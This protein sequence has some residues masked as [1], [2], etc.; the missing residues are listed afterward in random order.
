MNRCHHFGKFSCILNGMLNATYELLAW[1]EVLACCVCYVMVKNRFVFYIQLRLIVIR[2]RKYFTP[3]SNSTLNIIIFGLSTVFSAVCMPCVMVAAFFC[4]SI[5]FLC[6]YRVLFISCNKLVNVDSSFVHIFR[7]ACFFWGHAL[8]WHTSK[9]N[10]QLQFYCER[11]VSV[12]FFIVVF[13][14]IS[15]IW[16]IFCCS[17]ECTIAPMRNIVT[18]GMSVAGE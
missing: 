6:F 7:F 15:S 16:C 3:H 2:E 13:S 8:F 14:S 11:V 5:V 10:A 18:F 9:K 17:V 1:I 4:S 12:F